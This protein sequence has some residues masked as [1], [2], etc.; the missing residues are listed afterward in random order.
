MPQPPLRIAILECDTPFPNA[1]ETYGGFGGIFTSLLQSAITTHSEPLFHDSSSNITPGDVKI[2]KYH[3]VEKPDNYPK[4]D[5]VD[6]VLITGSKHN[7]F[8]DVPWINRLVEFVKE[9]LEN[10]RVKLVGVCFGH[11]VIGRAIGANVGRSDDGWELSVTPFRL[12]ETGK[13]VF[14]GREE[15]SLF[16]MHRDII[17]PG[18]LPST[19]PYPPSKPSNKLSVL[20][21][22]DHCSIQG[23]LLPGKFLTVQGHP[24]YNAT[25]V[26][27]VLKARHDMG[28][29]D[30][31][32]YHEAVER[33][34]DTHDGIVVGAEFL[35]FWLED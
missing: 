28:I 33:I 1:K 8:D 21:S 29:F 22:T 25:I 20:G 34:V 23:L 11:Q 35:R 3:V 18:T 30:D 16:Q 32:T 26:G 6:G 24:E 15:L 4:L 5:D 2:E 14:G 27:E 13:E 19:L 12:T 7:S 17:L 10:E 31:K 9:V